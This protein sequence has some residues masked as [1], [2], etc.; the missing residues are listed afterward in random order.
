M[1][2]LYSKGC[3]YAIR[4]LMHLP[5]DV[6]SNVGV[7]E[8]SDRAQIPEPFTRKMFQALAK[9]GILTAISGPNGGYRLARDPHRISL[10]E[11]IEIID[12]AESLNA[13]VLGLPV[14]E[15][16]NPCALHDAWSHA[17]RTLLPDLRGTSIADLSRSSEKDRMLRADRPL[18]RSKGRRRSRSSPPENP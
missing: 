7:Q 13:C 9:K 18:S 6:G 3:E 11:I 17:K 8:V 10:L 4:G 14:C 12:G 2:R 5:T 1:F 16:R 15:D